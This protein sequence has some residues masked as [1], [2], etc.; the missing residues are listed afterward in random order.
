MNTSVM[1]LKELRNDQ[2]LI[3]GLVISAE[4]IKELK[5]NLKPDTQFFQYVDN[6]HADMEQ[7]K[8]DS[9]E[10]MPNGL[11]I[12]ETNERTAKVTLEL[13]RNSFS[14]N[15]PVYYRDERTINENDFIRANPDGSEDLV[16]YDLDRRDYSVVKALLSEGKG[17][18][19]QLVG[20]K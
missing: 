20:S 7:L 11:T 18:I 9:N 4:D 13:Y 14:K 6:L 16:N 1:R 3:S 12:A 10:V 19:Y 8:R 5:T 2:G 17:V 15:V